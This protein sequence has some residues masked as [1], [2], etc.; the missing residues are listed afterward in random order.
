METLKLRRFGNSNGIIIP[1]TILKQI[2]IVD[3]TD[4]KFNINVDSNDGSIILSKKRRNKADEFDALF[5]NFDLKGYEK[6]NP[7]EFKEAWGKPV[8]KEVI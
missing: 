4:Q 7:D 8:G 3:V 1:K 5:D 2:G 6:N